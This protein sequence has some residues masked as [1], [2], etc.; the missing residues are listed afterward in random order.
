VQDDENFVD[1]STFAADAAAGNLASVSIVEGSDELGG[2]SPDEDPPADFEVGQQFMSQIIGAVMNGPQ[3]KDSA[4]FLTYDENGGM[5]DHV[6]PPAACAPDDF[7]LNN[8]S[9][10]GFTQYGFRVPLLVISPYAKRGYVSHELTD[11]TSILK[12]VQSRF[13]LAAFTRRDAN[14]APAYDM[15]DFAHPDFT[16]PTLPTPTVDQTALAGCTAA[17]PPSN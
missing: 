14:A 10:V 1:T 4:V 8:K 3:W 11:G 9:T 13:G 17:S 15:F 6:V 7:P 16:V 2:A 5:Y 12:F